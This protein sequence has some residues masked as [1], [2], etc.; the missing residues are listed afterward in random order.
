MS[1]KL[2]P[3]RGGAPISKLAPVEE[4][5]SSS[6]T[7]RRKLVPVVEAACGFRSPARCRD[8]A[9]PKLKQVAEGTRAQSLGGQRPIEVIN[10]SKEIKPDLNGKNHP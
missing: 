7:P 1:G 3:V 8:V 10:C 4:A 5:T 9:V 6:E 2:K